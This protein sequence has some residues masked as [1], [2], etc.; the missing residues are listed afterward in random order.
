MNAVSLPRVLFSF[1]QQAHSIFTT[2]LLFCSSFVIILFLFLFLFFF[3]CLCLNLYGIAEL[4][5]LF[6]C[7]CFCRCVLFLA[8]IIAT[9]LGLCLSLV[10]FSSLS[11]TADTA[12][13]YRVGFRLGSSSVSYTLQ[14]CCVDTTDDN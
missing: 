12:T 13:I 4:L 8:L 3:F 1:G 11:L 14:L 10:S 9:C 6:V 7:C 5:L 2:V